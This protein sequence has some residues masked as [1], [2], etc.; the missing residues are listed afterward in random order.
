MSTNVITFDTVTH[1]T[2][3]TDTATFATSANGSFTGVTTVQGLTETY[4]ALTDNSP[5]GHVATNAAIGS[6]FKVT[7]AGNRTLDNPTGATSDQVFRWKITQGGSGSNIITLDTKFELGDMAT[8]VFSTAVGA[9]DI[10]AAQYDSG[11][12][13]FHVLGLRKG[14]T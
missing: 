12:D 2:S 9:V 14:Y 13:K 6:F 10:L 1:A 7:V 3:S 4:Q 5:A 11:S 8:P